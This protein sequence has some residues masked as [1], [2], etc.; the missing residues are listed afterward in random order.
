MRVEHRVVSLLLTSNFYFRRA[1]FLEFLPGPQQYL[2][3]LLSVFWAIGQVVA[4][5]IC[6]VFIEKYS[7]D[8]V[9]VGV[10]EGYGD[11]FIFIFLSESKADSLNSYCHGQPVQLQITQ[12]GDIHII[13]SV[14]SCCFYRLFALFCFQWTSRRS[15]SFLVS[16]S[17]QIKLLFLERL[18]VR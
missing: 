14:L 9:L 12:G 3:T 7:C 6:W 16:K 15:F 5:L 4:S 11:F 13:L 18:H 8:A 2:L 1:L 10:V 17:K